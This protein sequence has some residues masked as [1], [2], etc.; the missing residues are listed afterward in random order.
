M[1]DKRSCNIVVICR[2]RQ[3]CHRLENLSNSYDVCSSG[4]ITLNNIQ[5]GSISTK[6]KPVLAVES[7]SEI[8]WVL[9]LCCMLFGFDIIVSVLFKFQKKH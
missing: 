3:R 4:R 1:K 8:V 6:L 7:K 2:R 9:K 5:V